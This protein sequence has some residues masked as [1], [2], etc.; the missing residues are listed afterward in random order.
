MGTRHKWRHHELKHMY[1]HTIKVHE[2]LFGTIS[3]Q[4]NAN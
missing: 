4:Q 2:N 3:H 1:V